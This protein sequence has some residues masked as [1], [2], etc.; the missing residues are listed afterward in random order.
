MKRKKGAAGKKGSGQYGIPMNW[1]ALSVRIEA[2]IEV[3]LITGV[4]ASMIA[5]FTTDLIDLVAHAKYYPDSTSAEQIQV[6]HKL[7]QPHVYEMPPTVIKE[8]AKKYQGVPAHN[9][10]AAIRA[11]M[12]RIARA[13][14]PASGDVES[15]LIGSAILKQAVKVRPLESVELLPD[16]AAAVHAEVT[17]H[18]KPNV[19]LQSLAIRIYLDELEKQGVQ[20]VDAARLRADLRAL[21]A[22]ELKNTPGYGAAAEPT[23]PLWRLLSARKV[24]TE[25]G[26]W[27]T[28]RAD[29]EG[30][31]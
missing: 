28:K 21:A 19:T 24:P 4:E 12:W 3:G 27:I 30:G 8:L 1:E 22:W 6:I 5:E 18:W 11:I 10:A 16:Q 2:F 23:A 9:R 26:E 25:V 29:D 31:R 7:L 20:G 17:R 15:V 13:L 14:Q